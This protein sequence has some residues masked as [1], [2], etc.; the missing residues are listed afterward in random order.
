MEE[1]S[2]AVAGHADRTGV[3]RPTPAA[4][5]EVVVEIVRGAGARERVV[6]VA[7][8]AQVRAVLRTLGEAPEGSA[9]LVDG[10]SIPLD[11]TIDRPLRLT[12]VPTFSGG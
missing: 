2:E 4:D 5:V 10:I 9:V 8:G 6:R 12:V 11:T 1:R 7:A 3:A